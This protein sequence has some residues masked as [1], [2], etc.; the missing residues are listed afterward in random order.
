MRGRRVLRKAAEAIAQAY[1]VE[2]TARN[3]ESVVSE[4]GR[5]HIAEAAAARLNRATRRALG[6]RGDGHL[7]P[8]ITHK[9]V[10][11]RRP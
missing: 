10:P 8:A 3:P 2:E 1:V 6:A 7:H 9:A 5:G 4:D 11:R